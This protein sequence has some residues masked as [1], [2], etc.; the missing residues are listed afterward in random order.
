MR[1]RS[2]A[3]LIQNNSLALME[4]RRAGLHYFSFPGGGVDEGET[5]EQ[6]V[7][8]E[9]REELGVEVRVVQLVAEVWFRGGQQF[10]FL[11]EQTDGTFGSGSGEEYASELDPARGSYEPR[12]MPLEQVTVQ[13]VL[14]K[15]V[16]ALVVQSHPDAWPERPVTFHE[17]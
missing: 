1:I 17:S 13:N 14:P 6:A 5:P 10:F 16:A 4:R 11:V 9:A 3:I 7:V 15:P 2:A 8:R 12:W